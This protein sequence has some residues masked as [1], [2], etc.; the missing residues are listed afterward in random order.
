M[1]AR[2]TVKIY[3][4]HTRAKQEQQ[5]KKKGLFVKKLR[6]QNELTVTRDA[7]LIWF[8]MFLYISVDGINLILMHN[9]PA[10]FLSN[11]Q[12]QILVNLTVEPNN[13]KQILNVSPAQQ[14]TKK[15]NINNKV[16]KRNNKSCYVDKKL[17]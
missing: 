10:S 11:S 8:F 2:R 13:N 4:I 7:L 12:Q 15:H 3:I 16:L 6:F 17:L 1:K 5:I 9:F 14:A